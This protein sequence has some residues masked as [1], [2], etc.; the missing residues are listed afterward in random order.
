M[1][2][3]VVTTATTTMFVWNMTMIGRVL[4]CMFIHL[5]DYDRITFF[6]TGI[7]LSDDPTHIHLPNIIISNNPNTMGY[8]G[9]T[10]TST[11]IISITATTIATI[12][13]LLQHS[14]L[15]AIHTAWTTTNVTL[16]ND[17][18]G[19]SSVEPMY[20]SPRDIFIQHLSDQYTNIVPVEYRHSIANVSNTGIGNKHTDENP[21]T[22]TKT[23]TQRINHIFRTL[24]ILVVISLLI[25]YRIQM[26]D[27]SPH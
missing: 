19:N 11:N 17:T 25:Q 22:T 18:T 10:P 13:V 16:M 14:N 20:M 12:R 5:V 27:S 1:F 24:H 3:P 26:M 9:T 23:I 15:P 21:A 4:H 8:C 2:R 7:R 6:S